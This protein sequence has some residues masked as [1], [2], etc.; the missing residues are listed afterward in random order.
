MSHRKR[1]RRHARKSISKGAVMHQSNDLAVRPAVAVTGGE[2]TPVR[3][4][5][6]KRPKRRSSDPPAF[7]PSDQTLHQQWLDCLSHPASIGP[8]V[9]LHESIGIIPLHLAVGKIID[10]WLSFDEPGKAHDMLEAAAVKLGTPA[11]PPEMLFELRDDQLHP[12]LPGPRRQP[13]GK[14]FFTVADAATHG[15]KS[16]DWY[17][18]EWLAT[19]DL[20]L[21]ER[22][23]RAGRAPSD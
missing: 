11:T 3:R 9:R 4:R 22:C 18:K 2:N 15:G 10:T 16:E 14:Q 13:D 6:K 17:R 21:H 7:Y 5:T 1:G 12:V 8:I 19:F 23:R 20:Q